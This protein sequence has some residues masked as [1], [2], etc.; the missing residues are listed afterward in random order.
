MNNCSGHR[1]SIFLATAVIL[2]SAAVCHAGLNINI[3]L[4]AIIAPAPQP[5]PPQP[6]YEA[7]APVEVVGEPPPVV[8]FQQPPQ[9]LYSAVLGYYVAVN[10]PH[11]MVFVDNTYYMHRHG[12]WF[13]ASS[14]SGPWVVAQAQYLPGGLRRFRWEQ[15][16]RYRDNEYRVYRRDPG[17]YQGRVLDHRA[18]AAVAER[19]AVERAEH[20]EGRAEARQV[21]RKEARVEQKN[22]E[23][24]KA[25]ANVTN[26]DAKGKTAKV[27]PQ[28]VAKKEEKKKDENKK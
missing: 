19:R 9:L 25:G 23:K 13:A 7:P 2:S 27:A 14:Y 21:E 12:Y 26:K 11:E 16:R 4:P 17:H 28:K 8:V 1:F 5:P 20:R 10:T 6:M 15:I 3:G 24:M 22:I 18:V